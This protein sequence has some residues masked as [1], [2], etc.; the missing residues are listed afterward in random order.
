MDEEEEVSLIGTAHEPKIYKNMVTIAPPNISNG[1]YVWNLF[2]DPKQFEIDQKLYQYADGIKTI[3]GAIDYHEAILRK[4][5][6]GKAHAERCVEARMGLILREFPSPTAEMHEYH[7]ELALNEIS[8]IQKANMFIHVMQPI[9]TQLKSTVIKYE[10]VYMQIKAGKDLRKINE[11]LKGMFAG[12]PTARV[13]DQVLSTTADF[14][15]M[16]SANSVLNEAS[17]SMDEATRAINGTDVLVSSEQIFNDRL[18]LMQLSKLPLPPRSPPP[19]PH[20]PLVEEA[21]AF[22]A[23]E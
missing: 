2:F 8:Q 20:I 7:R 4:Y 21:V 1:T 23:D 12:I 13:V 10:K 15:D 14:A 9:L 19:P 22:R 17:E 6:K 3:Y 5:S 16:T 11:A 18:A